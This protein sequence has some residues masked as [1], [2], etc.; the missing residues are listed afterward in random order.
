MAMGFREIDDFYVHQA[1]FSACSHD[2]ALPDE[3]LALWS[4]CLDNAT[5][6]NELS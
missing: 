4:Y 6:L 1:K 2:V 5:S 3:L